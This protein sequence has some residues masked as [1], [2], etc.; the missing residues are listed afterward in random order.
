[1]SEEREIMIVGVFVAS[2]ENFS[3]EH[4]QR[5]H[6][7]CGRNTHFISKIISN[8]M[9]AKKKAAKKKVAKKAAKKKKA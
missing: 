6:A 9:A 8:T 1:M 2:N 5:L 4:S 3:Q 7:V